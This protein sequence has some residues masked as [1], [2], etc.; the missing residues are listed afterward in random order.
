MSK[1]ERREIDEANLA[2]IYKEAVGEEEDIEFLKKR[3]GKALDDQKALEIENERLKEE[4][5]Q[6]SQVVKKDS[7]KKASEVE[8]EKYELVIDGINTEHFKPM[9][10]G[11]ILGKV[12]SPLRNRGWKRVEI[13]V[14]NAG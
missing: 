1:Y 13:W 11:L 7:F 4:K 14:R 2:E 8:G 5:T 12:I 3:L 10:I 9:D 6:L